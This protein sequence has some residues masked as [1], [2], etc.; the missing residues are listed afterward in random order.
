MDICFFL[1][2][3]ILD[4]DPDDLVPNLITRGKK[5]DYKMAE[6]LMLCVWWV[7]YRNYAI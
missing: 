4:P 6:L 1:F 7:W 5:I 2:Q 3:Q